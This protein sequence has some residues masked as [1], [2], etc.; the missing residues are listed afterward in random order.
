VPP[1]EWRLYIDYI[2]ASI[3]RIEEYTRDFT[4]EEFQT[5]SM[6]VEAVL[7]NFMIIGEAASRISPDLQR[8]LSSVPWPQ[9]R[10]MRN[11]IVHGYFA[12]ELE[13][14]WDTARNDLPTLVPP[15]RAAL[16]EEGDT[17]GSE[18]EREAPGS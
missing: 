13:V 3:A 14:V 10:A 2:L 16:A 4:F 12:V 6:R 1:R 17:I 5:D 9:M 18:T 8:R 11:I 15:L 7:H